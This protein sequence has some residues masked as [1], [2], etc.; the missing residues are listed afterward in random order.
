MPRP[1]HIAPL[2]AELV[3]Q[4]ERNAMAVVNIENFER[5]YKTIL[6]K[7]KE[8]IAERSH[9]ALDIDRLEDTIRRLGYVV[10]TKDNGL[11]DDEASA[12]A[13]PGGDRG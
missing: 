13:A 2:D 10:L 1:V 12:D 3:R 8:L 4:R 11:L 5:E 6:A 9:S 7:H